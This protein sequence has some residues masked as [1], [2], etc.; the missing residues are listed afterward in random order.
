MA[1]TVEDPS[2]PQTSGKN[3]VHH[4]I[5]SGLQ[6]S[7]LKISTFFCA[8]KCEMLY[9]P[10]LH[11]CSSCLAANEKCLRELEKESLT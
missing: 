5:P 10:S 8:E 2:G 4:T 3:I 1:K 7:P 11:I 9:Q 6:L